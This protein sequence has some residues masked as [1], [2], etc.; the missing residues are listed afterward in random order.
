[1]RG[2]IRCNQCREKDFTVQQRP[3]LSQWLCAECNDT[4]PSIT[5]V[6]LT[7]R[8]PLVPANAAAYTVF[9][10]EPEVHIL[11]HYTVDASRRQL[12]CFARHEAS[13]VVFGPDHN[14]VSRAMKSRWREP[15][16]NCNLR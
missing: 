9:A 8:H 5:V 14:V 7:E 12:R 10:S 1:M 4:K 13:H 2:F 11:W 15:D 3:G 6:T 16:V